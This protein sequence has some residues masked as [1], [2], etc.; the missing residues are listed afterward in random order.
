MEEDKKQRRR[1]GHPLLRGGGARKEPYTHGFSATQMMALTAVCGVLVPSLPPDAHHLAADK[2]VRDFFLASAADPPVPDERFAEIPVDRR[3]DALRRWSRETMLPPLR[4][5]FLLVK[6]FCLYVFYS[7]TDE[8]SENPHWRAIGYSPATDEAP[9]QEEQANTKRPL[10]DG[11]VETIH[12]TD[13]SLPIRLAEKGLAGTE[14]AARNLCTVERESQGEGLRRAL[15]ILVAAGATEVGTHRS[16]GQRLSC[17]GATDEE[18]EEFLD[19]VTGAERLYVCD[20]SVLPSAVGVN[21]M[22]TIQSVAYCLATGIAEQLKRDPSS[23]RNHST[24]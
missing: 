17:K 15:R 18:V 13:A 16:D 23:G 8:N 3:E 22:I 10:D 2:A 6:V 4:L 14:D 7:W 24:D 1:Q 19:G 11:V 20:G 21:P 5:F 12:H 9:E